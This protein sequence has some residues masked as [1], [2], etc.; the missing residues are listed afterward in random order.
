MKDLLRKQV[1][2]KLLPNLI[3]VSS[4]LFIYLFL[5]QVDAGLKNT[6]S[7]S[8]MIKGVKIRRLKIKV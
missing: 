4:A 3:R 2:L 8:V 5:K 1:L 7:L 6:D